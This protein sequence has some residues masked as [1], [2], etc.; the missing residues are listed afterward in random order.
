MALTACPAMGPDWEKRAACSV[1]VKRGETV[2]DQGEEE[3][4]R[5]NGEVGKQVNG[6]LDSGPP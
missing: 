2:E 6:T 4:K 5:D 1:G 3:S